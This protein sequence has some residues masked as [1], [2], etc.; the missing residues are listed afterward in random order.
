[1]IKQI[2]ANTFIDYCNQKD[3]RGFEYK[4]TSADRD[5]DRNLNPH[6]LPGNALDVSFRYRKDYAPIFMYNDFFKWL[7][8]NWPYRAGIDNTTGNIHIH[9]DLGGNRPEHQ[10]MPYFFKEDN[11][12]FQFQIK[13]EKDIERTS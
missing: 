7:M 12:K 3:I 2:F 6:A 5:G 13:S 8:S 9:L 10:A 11:G 4:I 1:M